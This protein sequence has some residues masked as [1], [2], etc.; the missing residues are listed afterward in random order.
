[1]R[2]PVSVVIPT[3]NAAA[4]LPETLGALGE[5]LSEGLIRELVI[6]D[7]GSADGTRAIAE[8]AGARLVT[9]AAGRGG[10]LARGAAAADGPWFLFL[11]ADTRLAPGWAAAALAHVGAPEARAGYFRLAFA[12]EGALPR[13]VAGWANLRARLFG[14][15]YGDQGLLVPRAVYTRPRRLCPDIPLMEDVALA[16][17]LAGRLAPLPATARDRRGALHAAGGLAAAGRRAISR[18]SRAISPGLPPARLA[19][20]YARSARLTRRAGG[21][22]PA[23]SR[24]SRRSAHVACQ[25]PSLPCDS[26]AVGDAGP[27]AERDA[28][29]RAQ[30]LHRRAA[31][32]R[33][34]A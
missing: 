26:R 25:R 19:R 4:A 24:L 33:G 28:P 32:D 11:H 8:A 20:F 7:G 12:A 2:A 14:L 31:R 23:R 16:R 13:L 18:R 15:P 1:M 27:G 21:V 22:A 5:G 10:Q 3:L 30:H 29:G 17:R 6:S 9:G 34:R